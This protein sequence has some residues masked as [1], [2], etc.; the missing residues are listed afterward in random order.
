ML[1]DICLKD[2]R[3]LDLEETRDNGVKTLRKL[4]T[5]SSNLQEQVRLLSSRMD[6][7]D[8]RHTDT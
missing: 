8:I 7:E 2:F 3:P 4:D 6:I 1:L 5:Q